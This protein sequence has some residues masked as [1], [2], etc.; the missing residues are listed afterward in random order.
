MMKNLV[1]GK[2]YYTPNYSGVANVELV[3]IIDNR[4]ALVR[5]KKGV[6]F[7]KS[8]RWLFENRDEAKHSG[9]KWENAK[10][11]SKKI[12]AKKKSWNGC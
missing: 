1:V 5:D 8:I 4:I 3:E 2:I 6:E 7:K 10:R 12:A 11:K 9:R